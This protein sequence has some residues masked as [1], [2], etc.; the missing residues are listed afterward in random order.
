MRY[1]PESRGAFD[2]RQLAR[3]LVEQEVDVSVPALDHW[4]ALLHGPQVVAEGILFEADFPRA[5][6]VRITGS[7]C[8]WSAQGFPLEKRED[9]VWECNLALENGQ[10]EYRFIV[11]GSWLPDPHNNRTVPNEFGGANSLVIVT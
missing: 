9:G 8:D 2:F 10:F 5:K 6:T 1:D 7:F 4:T 11:D 3:E